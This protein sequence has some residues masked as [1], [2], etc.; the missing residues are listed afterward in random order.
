MWRT[1]VAT[2]TGAG[3]VVVTDEAPGRLLDLLDT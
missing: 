1:H 3:V 2:L